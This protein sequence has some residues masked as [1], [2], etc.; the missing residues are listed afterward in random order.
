MSGVRIAIDAMGGDFAPEVNLEG[1]LRA[2][3]DVSDLR[4][5]LVGNRSQLIQELKKRKS[6]ESDRLTLVHSEDVIS[7]D[8]HGASVIRKK[9]NSSIHVGLQ[10]VKDGKADAFLSAGNSGAVMAGAL[11]L[12]GRLANVERPAILIKLP[13]AEGYIIILDAGANVDCRPSHLVQFAKMGEVYAK[14]IESIDSPRIALLS[15]GSEAHKGNELTRE[16][17]RVLSERREMN[18]IGYVE[19]YDLFRGK[20]DVVVCDGFVGNVTL[21]LAEG[22]ADTAFHWF[23]KA[24]RRDIVGL[25]GVVLMRKILKDF[26]AKFDYQPYG[27]AP[28]LGINGMV[29]ISHGSS[30]DVA[31]HNGILAA[32]RGVEQKFTEKIRD[33]LASATT[34]PPEEMKPKK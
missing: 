3:R 10:L 1:A 4:L 26:R 14:V 18:Y 2:L 7:M 25:V 34:D 32:K 5:T 15:N 23:R 11:L 6:G 8:D 24:I 12:L 16:T 29:L 20:A 30:T 9:P 33:N 22:L 31:I 27:A 17:N 21:K 19:G 28:L 13:T